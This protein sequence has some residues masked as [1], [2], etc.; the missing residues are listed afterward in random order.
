MT[1]GTG[2]QDEP[3][4]PAQPAQ[5]VQTSVPPQGQEPGVPPQ[6]VQPQTAPQGAPQDQPPGS[7]QGA[8]QLPV[9]ARQAET[10]QWQHTEPLEYHQLLRGV[11]RYR[12]WK[13]LVALVL[14]TIYYLTL[15]V[16]FALVVMVPY[17]VGGDFDVMDPEAFNDLIVIDTQQPF[18]I[19]IGLGSVAL[20]LPAALL[21]MLSVGLTPTGRI[22]SV[23]LRI[24]WRW[25]GRA[26]VPAIVSLLVTNIVGIA[27]EIAFADT[28][29]GSSSSEVEPIADFS[30][31]AAIWSLLIVIVLVPLQATAEEVVFRGAFMQAL[32]AWLGGARGPGGF[33][34]FVRGP[35]LPILIPAI[36]FGFAHIYDIWGWTFVVVLAVVAG[37][38]SWRTG[39]LEAAI[40]L[41]VINNLIALAIMASGMSGETAQTETGGGL[42]SII[43]AIVGFGLFA[44]WVDRDFRRKDGR[45]TRID[46]VERRVVSAAQ[47]QA[48]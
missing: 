48:A 15:S 26:V 14:G 5:P 9:W 35:W 27:L 20:M 19:L 23:A 33:A 1:F 17:A 47:G 21:A 11:A 39:G 44:W 32:G 4:T 29:V 43:G 24:R 36:A 12:W 3:F 38:L 7:P 37:W 45:R 18:S 8:Q 10:V 2:Q 46:I 13:P 41:H 30:A 6:G 28:P 16:V 40:T 31:Q 25:I 34:R 42:G 22:W